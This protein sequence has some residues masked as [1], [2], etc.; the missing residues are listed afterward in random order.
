M[1][2][3][4]QNTIVCA[5][6]RDNKSKGV[7][8]ALKII[9]LRS[10]PAGRKQLVENFYERRDLIIYSTDPEAPSDKVAVVEAII[11]TVE[12]ESPSE[13]IQ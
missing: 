1:R 13:A 10:L 3:W 6:D 5:N 9:L 2:Y 7:A 4:Y 12:K 8:A 11:Y